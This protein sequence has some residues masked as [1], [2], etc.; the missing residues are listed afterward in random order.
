MTELN[1]ELTLEEKLELIA[2]AIEAANGDT[3]KE[4]SL[5]ANI[6]DPQDSLNCDS[7]Q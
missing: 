1:N 2:K 3:Q 5:I 6:V 4:N 7:C